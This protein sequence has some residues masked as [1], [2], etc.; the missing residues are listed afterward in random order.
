MHLTNI[1]K[2]D[3]NN[4]TSPLE[5]IRFDPDTFGNSYIKLFD[6]EPIYIRDI[7]SAITE[8]ERTGINKIEDAD[9]IKHMRKIW[10]DYKKGKL[11]LSEDRFVEEKYKIKR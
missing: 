8:K 4:L 2:K 7:L 1:I 3:G 9:E 6:Y 11:L 5:K 10:Q